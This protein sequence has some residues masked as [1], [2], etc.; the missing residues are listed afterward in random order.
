MGEAQVFAG[1][2]IRAL[3]EFTQQLLLTRQSFALLSRSIQSPG[4][5]S[6]WTTQEGVRPSDLNPADN[7]AITMR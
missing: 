4:S 1:T 7:F 2:S 5:A 6:K 3:R